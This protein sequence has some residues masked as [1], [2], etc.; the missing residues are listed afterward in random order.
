MNCYFIKLINENHSFIYAKKRRICT[1][2]H[3]LLDWCSFSSHDLKSI[4][5]SKSRKTRF[6]QRIG[7]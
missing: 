4:T 7:L 6:Y 1:I 5:Q 2:N 3:L